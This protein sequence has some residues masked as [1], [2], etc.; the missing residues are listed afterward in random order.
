M[1][2]DGRTH[3]IIGVLGAG[4]EFL[5]Y[6]PEFYLPFQFNRAELFL[7]NFSYQGV[8]RLAD[9]VTIEQANA[10]VDR[11]IPVATELFPRGVSLEMLQDAGF[12]ASLHPLKQDAVGTVGS[13]LWILFGTVGLVLLIACASVANLFLVRADERR[14]E[15]A[16]RSALGASRSQVARGVLLE[17]VLRGLVG[18]LIGLGFAW[19]GLRILLAMAPDGLPRVDEIGIDANVL[20]FT[21]AV[22]ALSSL[23]FGMIPV[24]RVGRDFVGALKEGGRGGGAGRQRNRTRRM[25]VVAQVAMALVLAIGS[26]L[27]VRSFQA[28]RDVDPGFR[29]P[30][31]VLTARVTIPSAEI[32]NLEEVALAH[33]LIEQKLGELGGMIVVGAT[34]A[35]T[36]G[37]SDSSDVFQVEEFPV[38]EGQLPAVRRFKWVTPTYFE[39]MGNPLVAGRGITW[40]DVH[41]RAPVIVIS[42]NLAT[43]YWDTPAAALGKRMGLPP[44]EGLVQE[45]IWRRI[46]GVVGNV[47]DDGVHLD[48]PTIVFWPMAVAQF[49]GD[50]LFSPRSM[51]YVMRTTRLA[52]PS[53]QDEV[54][55]AVW[56][57]NSNLPLAAVR[58][59]DEIHRRSMART[60]FTL[61]MLGIAAAAALLLGAVGIYGVSSYMVAQRGREIGV[62]MALGAQHRDV[63]GMVLREGMML[64]GI[65]LVLGMAVAAGVTRLMTALLFGVSAIDPVTYVAVAL[66][67]ASVALCANYIPAMRATRVNPVEALRWK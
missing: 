35:V 22:S 27:I 61:V 37:G 56:S 47:H 41:D 50:E 34:S 29:N 15:V 17:T 53:L 46:V 44:L 49:W 19:G 20:G 11:L 55:Q 28:L 13:T 63:R 9:G 67:L 6:E 33:E 58:T 2:I 32:E 5:D 36:M 18:G 48:P 65:G 59:L 26:G 45:Q 42:E 39:T 43:E 64:A 4:V 21:L 30:E 3:E 57:V 54:R 40:A 23:L 12:A 8:A 1:R 7:G 10:D 31:E 38:G 24:L 62:R 16:V 60:S 51:V 14:Q 52:D 25:L 66:G